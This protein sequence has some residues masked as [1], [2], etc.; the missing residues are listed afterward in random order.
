MSIQ[1]Q[2]AV[3]HLQKAKGN[4]S[5]MSCHIERKDANG[6]QYVPENTDKS[7]AHLNRELIKFPAGV[8]CR[9]E[10]IMH[11]IKAAGVER[12]ISAKQNYCC[13]IKIVT[14]QKTWFGY[15]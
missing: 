3:C 5:G 9:T 14:T 11:R 12:K 2:Y 6:K 7:R 13:P 1:S 15:S 8:T 4:D 10:A